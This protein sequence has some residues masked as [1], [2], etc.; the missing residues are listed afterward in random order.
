MAA[1]DAAGRTYRLEPLDGSGVFL[2]LGAVQC[3][4]LGAG[5]TVAV[6]A[7]SAGLPAGLALV[8][9]LVAAVASFAR[10]GGRAAWEWLPAGAR[11]AST[12]LGR[13]ST[14]TA[15][16][17]L[18]PAGA[19]D[20]APLPPCL[21]GLELVEVPW[22]NESPLGAVRDSER[23]TLTAVVPVHGSP[24]V[25]QPAV[26]QD[27]LVRAWGDVLGQFA[28]E[29]GPVVHVGWSS[30]ARPSGLA[31]HRAWLESRPNIDSP[32]SPGQA[33][34]SYQE[35]V[36]T[37][38]T[39]VDR[40]EA[41][42]SVT[43]ARR[44]LRRSA[45]DTLGGDTADPLRAVLG[46]SVDAV[47]R[48]L[49]SADLDVGQPLDAAGLRRLL[50]VRVDPVGPAWGSRTGR[51]ADR[52]GYLPPSAAGPMVVETAWQHVRTDAAWHRTWWVASWPRTAV[53]AAWVEP[54]L[55]GGGVTLA[56]S[57]AMAPVSAYQSRR[58]IERDLV[59]LES[60][61]EAKEDRGRRVD[62]R[63]RRATESLLEREHELI[64]GY[65][66]MAYVG[67]VTVSATS[68]DEL[69]EHG[70]VVEQRAREAGLELRVLDGR[71]DVAWA[72]SLPFGLAPRTL[73]AS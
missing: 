52:L 34:A 50:R 11:W 28:V 2:G 72:A 71:Q 13:G 47:V 32:G 57:V 73:W 7:I 30:L 24:F 29:G 3:A 45:R 48:G 17:P 41:V 49:R 25:M 26:D 36:D 8:P 66:E 22:R 54:F 21:Q 9:S 58:R 14:W 62:A 10:V 19:D 1:D 42:V 68:R 40:F 67:L 15:P 6:V 38:A 53:P 59:K 20:P 35:A 18:W 37:I 39:V 43:V 27:R 55:T 12:R 63:H 69:D 46:S 33:T 61:A 65:A 16:L 70:D 5:I 31:E 4:L 23:H 60:D 51:L 44:R 56:V 64:A